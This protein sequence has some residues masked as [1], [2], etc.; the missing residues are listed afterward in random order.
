MIDLNNVSVSFDGQH[1]LDGIN[2]SM[3]QSEF[4]YLVGQTG[5]VKVLY[6]V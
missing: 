1:V 3:K 2:F 6:Y 4:V 5:M